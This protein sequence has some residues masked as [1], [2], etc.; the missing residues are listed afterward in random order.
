MIISNFKLIYGYKRL[1][2]HEQMEFGKI[3]KIVS[4]SI[5]KIYIGSTVKTL[6]ERLE[7]HET[8]Y[9]NWFNLD[10][11]K[12]YYCTSFEILKYGDY[13]I[14]LLEKYPCSSRSELIKHE[15]FY[16]IT[17]YYNCV[18]TSYCISRPKIHKIDDNE[19]Y[20]CYCGKKNAK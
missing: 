4:D 20:T 1:I 14:E 15:G 12:K 13:K 11:N 16:I 10:F 5:D 3:Y 7:R 17:N 2:I 19:F 8:S 9:E 18:N 6:E